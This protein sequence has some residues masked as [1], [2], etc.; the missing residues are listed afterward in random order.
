MLNYCFGY[1][2]VQ[3]G[4]LKCKN[5]QLFQDVDLHVPTVF[6]LGLSAMDVLRKDFKSVS[7][8]DTTIGLSSIPCSI[9]VKF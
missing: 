3:F 4:N 1:Y 5:L 9:E 6:L 7:D 2:T 8:Q